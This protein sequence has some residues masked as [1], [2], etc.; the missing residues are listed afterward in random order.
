[1]L[2]TLFSVCE[3]RARRTLT[4]FNEVPLK[5]YRFSALLVLSRTLLNSVDAPL[6]LGRPVDNGLILVTKKCL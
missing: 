5:V 1:M 3:L 4:I 2:V 6:V